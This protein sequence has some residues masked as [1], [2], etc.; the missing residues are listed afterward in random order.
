MITP[1]FLIEAIGFLAGSLAALSGLPRLREAMASSAVARGEN[2]TRNAMLVAANLLWIVVGSAQGLPS[3]TIMCAV[4][5][6]L[7]GT[8]LILA[9][10]AKRLPESPS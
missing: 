1:S 2:T 3:L 7:N 10:R 9:L 6:A 4:S 8:V 5:A